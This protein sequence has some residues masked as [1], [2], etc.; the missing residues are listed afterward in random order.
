MITVKYN[1]G[2]NPISPI[3]RSPFYVFR[4]LKIDPLPHEEHSIP[5][6]IVAALSSPLL[7]ALP[8][9]SLSSPARFPFSFP[10]PSPLNPLPSPSLHRK[11]N[12]G[13]VVLGAVISL[14]FSVGRGSQGSLFHGR[15]R[16]GCSTDSE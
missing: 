4:I 12:I 15:I 16:E 13:L 14:W 3:F 2:K 10:L 8:R 9:R 7:L 11:Q 1:K 6:I 5:R